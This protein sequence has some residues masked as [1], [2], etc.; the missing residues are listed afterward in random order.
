MSEAW[1]HL[2]KVAHLHAD[3][4]GLLVERRVRDA[5]EY[6]AARDGQVERV[7]GRLVDDNLMGSPRREEARGEGHSESAGNG[8]GGNSR[9]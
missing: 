4:A 6:H 8:H 2:K 7:H 1:L 9:R 5:T 3:V